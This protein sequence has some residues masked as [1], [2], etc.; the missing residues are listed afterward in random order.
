MFFFFFF[1]FFLS[2]VV[3]CFTLFIYFGA[4]GAVDVVFGLAGCSF[5]VLERFY[6]LSYSMLI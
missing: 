2:L 1:F 4:A 6:D 3:V 5:F